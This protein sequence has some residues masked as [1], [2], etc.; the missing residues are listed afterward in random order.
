MVALHCSWLAYLVYISFFET[1]NFESLYFFVGL[2]LFIC[3]QILRVSAIYTLGKRW[4]TRVVVLPQAD[5]VKSGLFK[6][7][8]HPNYLG[9]ILELFALPMMGGLFVAAVTFSLLNGVILFFRIRFEE[10]MLDQYN[11]YYQHFSKGI[12]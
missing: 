2:G 1:I 3:G 6:F 5:V 7:I 11:N 4:S 9:V 12:N 10:E 8:K